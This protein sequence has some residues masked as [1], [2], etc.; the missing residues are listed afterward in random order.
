MG[1]WWE[2]EGT[3]TLYHGTNEDKSQS[4]LKEGFKPVDVDEAIDSALRRLNLSRAMVPEWIW[5]YELSY[6]K[7]K[8]DTHFSTQK[9]QAE[10]YAKGALWG[11]EIETC[12]F[13]AMRRW[14]KELTG[15]DLNFPAP[16]PVVITVDVPWEVV[17]THLSDEELREVKVRV[18]ELAQRRGQDP[19]EIFRDVGYQFTASGPIPASY[20]TKWEFV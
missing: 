9:A 17:K 1:N 11:G 18:T 16:K 14:M 12:V 15:K 4:I 5:K 10:A 8:P 13:E 19:A 6:R 3:V 2:F 20:I 7:D